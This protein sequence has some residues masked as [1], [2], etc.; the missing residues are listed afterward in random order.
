MIATAGDEVASLIPMPTSGEL[1][2]YVHIPFC[3]YKC[4]YCHFYVIQDKESLKDQLLKGLLTE[5]TSWEEHVQDRK[6]VSVYFGGGTPSL[7]GPKRIEALL[8]HIEPDG[9]CEVTIEANPENITSEL[10]RDYLQAGINRV[11]IGVQSFD[12]GELSLLG[13]RHEASKAEKAIH[14]T[15]EAGCK[16]ISIDLMYEVPRQTI[17]SWDKTLHRVATLPIT[18]LSLYNLQIEPYTPFAKRESELRKL[19][20]DDETGAAMYREAISQLAKIG[21]QQYEISAFCRDGLYSRHNV[22]Y[23]IGREFLGLGPSAFSYY[24][25]ERF[26]NVAN[27]VRYCKA[28]EAGGSPIDFRDEVTPGKR[29]RELLAIGLRLNQGIDLSRWHPLDGETQKAIQVLVN[30]GL[31]QENAQHIALT[32]KGILFYDLVA[33][34]II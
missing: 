1:S 5:M 24:E 3:T 28:L 13:R 14:T 12:D 26:Q 21:L 11:S 30:Q 29:V 10:M 19:M 32:E 6:I 33:S 25:G 15:F 9:D 7:F 34:E 27:L 18:H 2:L 31:L 17:T 22:G 8:N 16:N 4:P 23:W 20:P